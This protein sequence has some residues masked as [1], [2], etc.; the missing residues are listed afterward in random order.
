MLNYPLI[1]DQRPGRTATEAIL[2]PWAP[3]GQR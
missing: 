1:P 3:Y 2:T